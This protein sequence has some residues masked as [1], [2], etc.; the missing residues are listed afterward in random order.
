MFGDG[1]VPML[2]TTAENRITS[3]VRGCAGDQLTDST[4]RSGPRPPRV[5]G[6]APVAGA[7]DGGAGADVGDAGPAVDGAGV[8]PPGSVQVGSRPT[9]VPVS[10]T[11]PLSRRVSV[12]E[13]VS[14]LRITS[15]GTTTGTVLSTSTTSAEVTA[16]RLG[17]GRPRMVR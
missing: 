11:R 13:R 17:S 3:P 6:C 9:A 2:R 8:G 15:S 4:T 5:A 7:A 16:E 10:G 1:S 14:S 12:S